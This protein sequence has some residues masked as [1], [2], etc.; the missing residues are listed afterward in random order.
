MIFPGQVILIPVEDELPPPPSGGSVY[1]V[2]LGD[3]LFGIAQQF[4]I[5][6]DEL[7]AANPQI[8]DPDIIFTGQ[9]IVIPPLTNA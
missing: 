6:L 2:Q 5:D 7:I 1:I 8:T 4:G 9:F 3:T